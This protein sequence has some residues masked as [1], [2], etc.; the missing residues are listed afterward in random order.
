MFSSFPVELLVEL[1]LA[2]AGAIVLE[3]VVSKSRLLMWSE[4]ISLACRS[5][6]SEICFEFDE[7]DRKGLVEPP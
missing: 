6:A 3:D 2:A 1:E 5:A 4:I 7:F